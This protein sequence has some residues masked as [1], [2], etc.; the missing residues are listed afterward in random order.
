MIKEDDIQYSERDKIS[1]EKKTEKQKKTGQKI[2][3]IAVDLCIAV[4]QTKQRI[5]PKAGSDFVG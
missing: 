1:R 5:N 3:A 2:F 4:Q